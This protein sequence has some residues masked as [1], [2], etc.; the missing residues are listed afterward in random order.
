MCLTSNQVSLCQPK[1]TKAVEDELEHS[2]LLLDLFSAMQES[3]DEHSGGAIDY[4]RGDI[5]AVEAKI[6]F[7]S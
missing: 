6:Q 4:Q 3:K 2:L 1:Q 7:R 5:T